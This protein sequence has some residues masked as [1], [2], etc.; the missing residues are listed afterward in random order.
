MLGRR[1]CVLL[2]ILIPIPVRA[3]DPKNTEFFEKKVR[4]LLVNQCLECHG[5]AGKK[6]K[7]KLRLT[8]RA[9][10]LKG[11]AGGSA[12]V[13][14]KPNKSR[15][16]EAV[17]YKNED[18][19][20]PPKGRLSDADIA[21][22][23]AWVKNGAVWP[24]V[25]TTK[26]VRKP[27][28]LFTDEQKRFWAF[29]PMKD[30]PPPA[31]RDT[32]W[33]RTPIDAFILAKL[34]AK[35]LK[36]AKPADKYTLLRRVTFDLT[37]LPPTVEEIRNFIEDNSPNAF[38]KVVDRLLASPAYGERWGRHWLDV[39][40]YADSN[41]LDENTAFGNA[42]RY[43]DY[44]IKSFNEDKPY[45]QFL[46]EQIAGDLLPDANK[47]PD[48]LTGT[49]FLVLGP[50]VLAEP[51]KQKMKM[52]IADE[53]VD[54]LGKA[55]LGLTLGCARCHDHKF[56]P[57]PQRDYYSLLSIFT[58]T[59][60]MKNLATVAH[61]FERP[62]P[63]GEKPEEAEARA[64][65]IE[66]KQAEIKKLTDELR[67][68]VL[69]DARANVAAYLLAT[70][71]ARGRPGVA[72]MS[73]GHKIPGT[74]VLE[75]EKYAAGTA[76]KSFT[77]YGE[78]IGII[79]SYKPANT[80]A[81]YTIT[82]PKAGEYELELRYAA[83][84]SR[85]VRISVAG[86]VVLPHAAGGTT[87]GW[88]PENQAWK[89]EGRI[90]LAAG[91][92]TLLIEAVGLL[93]HIDKLA[94]LPI[95]EPKADGKVRPS[96]GTRAEVSRKRKLILEFIE[97]WADYLRTVKLDDPTFGPWLAV[98]DLPDP[99]FEAACTSLLNRF[100]GKSPAGLLDGTAPKS[101]GEF[102]SR[103]AKVLTGNKLLAEPDGTIR[104]QDATPRESRTVLPDGDS[105][106][107]HRERRTRCDSEDRPDAGHGARRR[108][109]GALSAGE[110][111]WQAAQPL[112]ATSGQLPDAR[113]GSAA[114]LPTHS[115]GRKAKAIRGSE[116]RTASRG[117]ESDALRPRA[118]DERAAGAGELD[119]ESNPPAHRAGDRQSRLAAP[120][121]RGTGSQPGQFWQARRAAHTSGVARLAGD[122]IRREWLVDQETAQAHSVVIGLSTIGRVRSPQSPVRSRSGQQAAL[123]NEPRAIGSR[124]DPRCASERRGQSR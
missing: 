9:E 96:A 23:E 22:L 109:R 66:A 77:G 33:V 31:V 70:A 89:P 28:Q 79:L 85:P 27:G 19:Q 35:S 69:A 122:A 5:A 113:R 91:K 7:G 107:I 10:M 36:P 105:P 1:G 6:V 62:L 25:E 102:A 53:Q 108:G 63:T 26:V 48:R 90:P 116:W 16:I 121:R 112:C 68:K 20:M 38:E 92:N 110:G 32:G 59:R 2:L 106:P 88:N 82:V 78:G 42:W 124:A 14:G 12:L 100:R 72:R 57:I 114:D 93:P 17:R 73:A 45:D 11:G 18:L 111:G 95:E 98:K 94:V 119:Y 34:E 13:P 58:S 40:R 99:G 44:V 21:I 39:A 43:R 46:R 64:K 24:N 120:F 115:G 117:S 97:G 80:R 52:D 15:L 8:S 74:I 118:T 54:T 56:D 29:Q 123:A 67:A 49:G 104:A 30:A 4:P 81:E 103:Y 50:K 61:A 37:G 83:S 60:T 47:N 75:A 86:K 71:D 101:L 51:D 87:G 84:A 65:K 76:D 3:Q 55:V 41:G